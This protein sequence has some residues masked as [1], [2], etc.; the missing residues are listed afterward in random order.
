MKRGNFVI[1]LVVIFL[2]SP[3]LVFAENET[4]EFDIQKGF[5]WLHDEMTSN[6]WGS[7]VVSLSWSILALRNG[8]YDVDDGIERLEQLENSNYNWDNDVYDTSM[9]ILALHKSGENIEDEKTW[10]LDQQKRALRSGQWL[11]QL[12]YDGETECKITY[13]GDDFEFTV[14]DTEIVQPSDCSSAIGDPWIDFEQCI[15]DDDAEM[16][17]TIGVSCLDS[18]D[19]SL[20][21]RS[22]NDYYIVDQDK[23]LK[24]ENACFYGSNSGCSCSSTQYASWALQELGDR[25]LTIPYLRSKCN[26]RVLDDVFLYMLTSS[27]LYSNS[28]LEGKNA[29]ANDGGWDNDYEKTAMAVIAL[30]DSPSRVST[31][32]NWLEFWQDP[33]GSWDQDIATTAKVL[34]AMTAEA[35]THV[36]NDTTSFCNYNGIVDGGEEC[37]VTSHCYE[38]DTVCEGCLCIPLIDCTSNPEICDDG[39]E[40]VV[41]RCVEESECDTTNDCIDTYGAGYECRNG[42]CDSVFVDQDECAT[43]FDCEGKYGEGW[44]CD[45]GECIEKGSSWLTWLIVTLIIIVG[46]IGAWFGYKQFYLKRKGPRPWEKVANQKKLPTTGSPSPYPAARRSIPARRPVVPSAQ[47][48]GVD[49]LERQ[50]DNSL[51][52]ARDLLR[53]K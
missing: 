50:L 29:R 8:G 47:P 24:I 48:V 45:G 9:A 34:Y 28:L 33:D 27:S 12:L 39:Y 13:E 7:D 49:R 42:Q 35:Y 3:L 52:K 44:E 2:I 32:I 11:I 46:L 37:E 31:S 36:S 10:L 38:P 30:R 20:L 4:D 40:C 41:G 19:S 26:D 14:N 18:V 6:G 43:N 17:E 5:E 21:F 51:K 53:K 22:G 15:A 1:L 23:P 25:P 16:V